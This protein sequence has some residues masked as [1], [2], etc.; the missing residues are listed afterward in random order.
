MS[1]DK[2]SS[3]LSPA[4]LKIFCELYQKVE[5]V[6]GRMGNVDEAYRRLIQSLAK[7]KK[8]GELEKLV[9]NTRQKEGW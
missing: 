5:F 3:S 8:L 1:N 2:N 6:H 9:K 7:E 4:A